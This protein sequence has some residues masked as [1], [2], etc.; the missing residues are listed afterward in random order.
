MED[1]RELTSDRT[2]G[3]PS[4]SDDVS[5]ARS[6][7]GDLP[8]FLLDSRLVLEELSPRALEWLLQTLEFERGFLLLEGTG[9]DATPV[10]SDVAFRI[11]AS[12][13]G[14]VTDGYVEWKEVINPEFALNRSVVQRAFAATG[15]LAVNDC[16][17][18]PESGAPEQ[19]RAVLSQC[20]S[21]GAE[22]RGVLYIDRGMGRGSIDGVEREAF[23]TLL[24]GCLPALA[25]GHLSAEV[26]RLREKVRHLESIGRDK[27]DGETE[28]GPEDEESFWNSDEDVPIF[29][30]IVGRDSK[31]QKIFS[32]IEKI[33]D[34]GLNVCIF[35]ESGT[36]KE[37]VARAI[38][39]AGNRSHHSFVAENCG[40]ISEN[41]LESELFGHVKGAFTGAD[42]DRQGLFELADKGTLF[43][44]EIGDMSEVMQRKLLRSIQ[45]GII[46]PIGSKKSIH[47]DVRVLCASNRDLMHLVRE[48]KFRTDLYYRL[49][50][51]QLHIP[52]LRERKEDLTFLIDYFTRSFAIEEGVKKRL[53]ESAIRALSQ[54]SW[55]GN[56]RELRNVIRRVLLTCPR[57]VVARKDVVPFL[58]NEQATACLG[59]NLERDDNQL[60]LRIPLRK[61]FNEIIDE[62]ERLVLL[63]ALKEHGW[64]KSRVTKALGIPRQSLYNKIAKYDLQKEWSEE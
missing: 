57:R 35:G 43:L 59:E 18:Q 9:A 13:V 5:V 3:P 44:D 8:R 19:H 64:N 46:R 1:T 27:P 45:E 20:F 7:V 50:V 34:S 32:I 21:L 30:G 29:H 36:G 63:N 40:A 56:I 12:R 6:R 37:L 55:P 58:S 4:G 22:G 23:V 47:V 14:K 61:E 51:I 25:R 42:E 15:V 31:L 33:K 48:G 39:D 24:E 49:N 52:P 10:G 62:C 2:E 53:G 26:L 54:Y 28:D 60:V 41:L 38:H 11:V 17:I 16:L